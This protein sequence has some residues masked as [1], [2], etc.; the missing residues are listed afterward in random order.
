MRA[1]A[2]VVL[3]VGVLAGVG[4]SVSDVDAASLCGRRDR[5]ETGIAGDVPLADQLSGRADQGYN[6]GLALVGY[7]SLGGRGGNANMAWA[8]D[9]AYVSGDGIAVVDVSDPTHPRHVR[10]LHGAG[11]DATVETLNAVVT[12]D[13]ALLVTGRYGLAGASAL[14]SDPAPVDVWDVRNCRNPR[15]LSTIELPSNAHNL[16]LTADGTR[17]WNTLPLQAVDLTDPRNPVYLGN[18]ED[19]LRAAGSFHLEYA[20]EAWPSPDGT[21][22]YVGGQMGGDEALTIIDVTD[23][24]ARPA[25]VVAETAGPGHSIRPATIDGRPYLLHSDESIVNPTAKGCVPDVFTPVGGASQPFLTDIGDETAPRTVGQFRLPINDP[26]N[27][28]AEVASG[29]N[30][31]VHYHDVDDPDDTTFAMLSMWNAGLRVVDVRDPAHPTE[32]AYFNPGRFRVPDTSGGTQVGAALA[33]QSPGELDQAWAHSRY[34]PETGQI[35]LATRSGGFWV[36]EL[37]PQV[38]AALGLAP[39]P[40]RYPNGRA[41]RPAPTQLAIETR[42]NTALYC[43]LAPLG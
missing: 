15:H 33:L 20:H 4:S 18:L 32:V 23:W 6:C 22:L 38:R 19:Q 7:N 8:G 10:T 9:C 43:T 16:T 12:P 41:P 13:R 11:S 2:V 35:W 26:V 34:V 17:L 27:C 40:T 36:L 21:R 3:V 37:E 25:R 1:L 5:P 14:P 24:P 30:A 31:S 42:F 29:V 39:V 28:L